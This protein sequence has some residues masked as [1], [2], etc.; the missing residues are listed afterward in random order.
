MK[1]ETCKKKNLLVDFHNHFHFID[2]IVNHMKND[3]N[4][5]I[6]QWNPNEKEKREQLLKT[7]DIIFCE[8]AVEN[9]VWYS[10]NKGENQKL[11]V[12]VHRWEIFTK[13][14]FSIDWTKVDKVIFISPEMERLSKLRLSTY[15]LL[16]ADNFDREYY[17]EN[18]KEFFWEKITI[19]EAWEHFNKIQEK[20][21][22][23][24]NFKLNSGN[25]EEI[26][27]KSTMIYNY[28]KSPMFENLPKIEGYEF[29]IGMMGF[30]PRIK[31]IDIAIEILRIMVSK[32][33]RFRLFVLGKSIDDLS[34][35][36]N[37]PIEKKY[38]ENVHEKIKEYN[39]SEHVIF[40]KYTDEPYYWMQKIGYLL[41]VSNVEGSHQ[42]VA[43]S[44]ASGIIPFIYGNALK[45]YKLDEIYPKKYCFYDSL[46]ELCDKILYFSQNRDEREAI[47]I[48]GKQYSL[49]HFK[50][51]NIYRMFQSIF[52]P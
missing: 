14:F 9:A 23:V 1:I 29:N 33:K 4:V 51:Q 12:R 18:N 25:Y 35:L 50:V 26:P 36:K 41:P 13:H 6:C 47:A 27:L 2:E 19:D 5:N 34:W 32:D 16:N 39:L 15:N 49:K 43:E 37:D 52:P 28:V 24:L 44:L 46:N 40:E 17:I 10:H 8:W 31:R 38:F 20:Q 45:Q 21:K 30:T 22:R 48:E 3:Y 11:Y 42:A 7:A